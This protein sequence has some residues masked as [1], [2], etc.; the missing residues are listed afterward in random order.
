MNLRGFIHTCKNKYL[1]ITRGI[2]CCDLASLDTYQAKRLAKELKL[3]RNYTK[4]Y[5]PQLTYD[6]WLE[7]LDAMIYSFEYYAS[8]KKY[9]ENPTAAELI[10]VNKGLHIYAAY[11][12]HLWS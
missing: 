11:F 10:R 8:N 2:G 1:Q 9:I 7:K 5:P 12:S 3:F 4:S 6:E